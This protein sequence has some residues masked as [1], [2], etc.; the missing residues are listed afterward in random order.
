MGN[1]IED[2]KRY[3]LTDP[4][5]AP[6]AGAFLWNRQM[7]LQMTCRGYATAQFMQPEPAKYAH[8]PMLA[9]K[10]FM[11]PEHPYFAHHPGRFFYINDHSENSLWSAPYEPVR[12]PV[13]N[14]RFEP[15]LSDIRWVLEKDNVTIELTVTLANNEPLER[16]TVR[17]ANSG[18]EAKRL[19][20]T[21]YFPVGYSSWMNMSADFN[22]DLKAVIAR[23]ISPYQKL[24]D[25]EVQKNFKDLTYLMASEAPNSWA[26]SMHNFEGEGGL[27][28]P[29]ALKDNSLDNQPALYESPACIMQFKFH[30]EPNA[31][32]TWQFLFG[33]AQSDQEIADLGNTHLNA[34]EIAQDE[35]RYQQ[36]IE[37]GLNHFTLKSPDTEFNHFVNYWL[38][39]QLHY[40]GDSQRLTTDPQTRNYLQDA[41]GMA[42]I[43]AEK[44]KTALLTALSQQKQNGQMPDGI[45]LNENAELKYINKIPHTDHGVWVIICLQAY[46]NETGDTDF[47]AQQIGFADSNKLD[48]VFNH[49]CLSLEW[50]LADRDERGLSYIAQGDWCDPMNMV[51]PKGIGVSGWLTQALTYAIKLWLPICEVIDQSR[52]LHYQHYYDEL[53]NII[54]SKLWDGSW[55][56]RGY[57][58]ENRAFGTQQV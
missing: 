48:T 3:L 16:W 42:Y 25:Y 49:V 40:H 27:H 5:V 58:D 15:G 50:L 53:K 45:L 41:M 20:L 37:Q 43:N 44:T 21:P 1:F 6:K 31:S 52:A 9:A 8:G 14:F 4:L 33:P 32:K 51:G 54:N 34:N 47:L 22:P 26:T 38:P 23:C 12:A 29:D 55:Y 30:L 2:G 28:N 11:Q 10:S 57:T 56:L 35:K 13:D 39:R 19:T 17:V 24:E 46:L 36:Y 18:N 7:M